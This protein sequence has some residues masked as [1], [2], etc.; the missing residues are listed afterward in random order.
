[1]DQGNGT[2]ARYTE[3]FQFFMAPT[4]HTGGNPRPDLAAHVI[5]NSWGCPPSEG[6][7]DP[8]VLKAIV[9]NVRAAGIVVVVSAGNSGPACSTISDVPAFYVASFSNGATTCADAI[10]SFSS[11]GPITVSGSNRLKP[12]LSRRRGAW[13]RP[14]GV[15][16][17]LLRHVRLGAARDRG[18]RPSLVGRAAVDRP[19][20]RDDER[21]R[22]DR[23]A[24]H[25]DAGLRR[26]LRRER[27]EPRLRVGPPGCGR[28]GDGL[29]S[30]AH[31][32]EGRSGA[33]QGR[34]APLE[35]GATRLS[36]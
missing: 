13:R 3:C 7:T 15:Y 23:G 21:A 6:C 26:V 18:R 16:Q 30:L 12:D 1:M 27:P 9:E 20:R 11:R 24:A 5:N 17:F 22:A 36:F 33:A 31:E 4:D 2:P 28:G 19:G 25:L 32:T 29:P 35:P 34:N 14:R 8:A 10:A